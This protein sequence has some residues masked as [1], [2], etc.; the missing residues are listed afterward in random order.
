MSVHEYSLRFTQLSRYS[1][2][3]VTDL[4]SRMSL[5]VAG[6]SRQSSKEGKAVMLIGDMDLARL[7]IHKPKGP[8]PSSGSAFAPKNKSEYNS[9]NSYSFRAKLAYSQGSIAQR[10]SKPPAFAP[11]DRASPRGTTSDTGGG[12]YHLSEFTFYNSY[13]A[14]NFHVIPEQCSEPFSVS[15]T[16]GDSILTER[17]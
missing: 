12:T 9:Q 11:P 5:F 7:M 10:G 15:T 4:R 6:S 13:V 14:M 3:M 17:V 16:V 2:E 1:P 8:A